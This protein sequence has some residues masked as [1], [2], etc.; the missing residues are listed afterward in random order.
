MPSTYA[1]YR[2]GATVLDMLSPETRRIVAWH[3][4]LYYMGLHGPDLLFYYKPLGTNH[5]NATGYGLHD[6]T[7]LEFFSGAAQR[8]CQRPDGE[9]YLSYTYGFLCHFVLDSV[10]HGYIAQAMTE[11]GISHTELESELDRSLLV[12]DG[13]DPVTKHLTDHI[14]PSPQS[15]EII[16]RFF[17]GIRPQEILKAQRAYIF[18]NNLLVAP[19][20]LHR[21]LIFGVLRLSGHYED[22]HGL[23]INRQPNPRCRATTAHLYRLYEQAMPTAAALIDGYR[24]TISGAA[25]WDNQY[26][27]TFSGTVKQEG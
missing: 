26:R 4:D 2:F 25:P 14:H 11:T 17:P 16:C 18:Y 10:C 7:G 21:G 13:F 8:L 19:S 27:Y 24:G 3:P 15:A 22:M 9:A 20:G 1:H 12:R 6:H 23:V 5:V